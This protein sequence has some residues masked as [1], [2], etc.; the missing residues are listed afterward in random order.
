MGQIYAMMIAGITVVLALVAWM[1]LAYSLVGGGG[2]SVGSIINAFLAP[3]GAFVTKIAQVRS[4]LSTH[5]PHLV[6]CLLMPL[7]SLAAPKG[8][9]PCERFTA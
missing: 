4:A 7:L 9:G 3:I 8:L 6:Q 1:G 2:G 5:A